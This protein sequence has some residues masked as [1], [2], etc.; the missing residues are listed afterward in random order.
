MRTINKY[1]Y[2]LAAAALVGVASCEKEKE[3]Y[4]PGTPD[5]ET[6]EGVYFIKQDVIEETQ[7]FDPTQEKKA[8]IK[9]HRTNSVGA[10]TVTPKVSLSEM[11]SSGPVDGDASLFT[12][13]DIVFEDGQEEAIMTLSFPNVKE[14]VQYSLHLKIEGDQYASKYTSSLIACDYNMMCVKY[15]DFLNPVTKQPALITFKSSWWEETHTAYVKY[16]EVDGV[17]HCV[18]YDEKL[19]GIPGVDGGADGF[20]GT[21]KDVHFAFL[22]YVKGVDECSDCGESHPCKVPSGY[23]VP[24]GSY[25]LTPDSPQYI[26]THSSA[27]DIFFHDQYLVS[28]NFRSYTKS[29]LHYT[30]ANDLFDSTSYYDGNGGFYFYSEYNVNNAGS[31]WGISA[32]D[33]VGI[34][35]GFV[36]A[37]FKLE[38]TAGVTEVDDEGNNVVPISFK[39][40]SDSDL[41]GY[42]ILPGKATG[43]AITAEVAAITKETEAMAKEKEA[44]LNDNVDFSK[45]NSTWVLASGKS[46]KDSVAPEDGETGFFTLVAVAVDTIQVRTTGV[47]SEVKLEVKNEASLNF[48][49]IN[50]GETNPVILN[51]AAGSTEKYI[52]RGYDPETSFEYTISGAGLTGVI[53]MIYTEAEVEAE[54]GIDSILEDVLS[55]PNYFYSALSLEENNPSL[56]AQQLADVNDKGFSDIY[57]SGVT[58]GT[59]YYVIVWATNGYDCDVAYATTLT[60]GDPLPIYQSF[61]YK[62]RADE[63]I[64]GKSA[65]DFYGTYNLYAID[66]NG[67]SSLRRYMGQAVIAAYDSE[68]YGAVEVNGESAQ[69]TGLS[70]GVGG[71][72]FDDTILLDFCENPLGVDDKLG[73]FVAGTSTADG[74]SAA[75]YT[76][77]PAGNNFYRWDY[78]S[79]AYPVMDGYIAFVGESYYSDNYGYYSNINFYNGVIDETFRDF[80]LVDPAKDDNGLAPKVAAAI[81]SIKKVKGKKIESN[82]GAKLNVLNNVNY[83]PIQNHFFAPVGV[84]GLQP[85]VSVKEVVAFKHNVSLSSKKGVVE[86]SQ[87]PIQCFNR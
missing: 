29:F 41:V 23:E 67:S 39:L 30:D 66:M 61:T 3:A 46:F 6:C 83:N 81:S 64:D 75:L 36:R 24:A 73:L 47:V 56:T 44:W 13:S 17:R 55:D 2:L 32:F 62:N 31:G 37:D 5:S 54:G 42:S 74:K 9:V 8:E 70:C 71:S 59:T 22:W 53:P 38:L 58:P 63:L 65:S 1:F 15:E 86:I 26:F 48:Q 10:L 82:Y 14:G 50:T 43:S 16:Y 80:L 21:G 78:A 60:A 79:V 87:S 27:G 20:W 57:T 35:D 18:T 68:K 49:Y 4:A 34:A 84:T 77:V 85:V 25:L 45:Y 12:V 40:G 52:S 19:V 33:L 28:V 72:G 51:V 69:I 7:I 76:W 11:T